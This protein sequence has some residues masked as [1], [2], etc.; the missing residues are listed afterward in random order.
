MW[1]QHL[2]KGLEVRGFKQSQLDPC[3][4]LRGD[5]LFTVYCDDGIFFAKSDKA[6]DG[7]IASLQKPL[8]GHPDGHTFDLEVES[9]LAGYLGVKL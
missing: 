7:A 1:Y 3:L 8:K 4:Y 5:V 2:R 9:D 6:I